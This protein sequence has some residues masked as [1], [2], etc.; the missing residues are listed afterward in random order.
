[1]RETFLIHRSSFIA[2]PSSFRRESLGGVT[3]FVTMAYIIVLNPAILSHAKLENEGELPLGAITVAT[4]LSAMVGTLLMGLYAN[5]PLAVAPY[6]GENAFNGLTAG[7]VLY[8]VFK[9]AAGLGDRRRFKEVNLGSVVLAAWATED[10][11]W[12]ILSSACRIDKNWLVVS[13]P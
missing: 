6:M 4:I 2:H 8:P 3:T 7:L 13:S 5:R 11:A 9:L 10:C 1:L 12:S